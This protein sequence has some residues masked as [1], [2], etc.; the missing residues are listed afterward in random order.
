ME[1]QEG[2]FLEGD[3]DIPEHMKTATIG[4]EGV[5]P[6]EKRAEAKKTSSCNSCYLGDAFRCNSCPYLGEL[7]LPLPIPIPTRP[8]MT[9]QSSLSPSL[10]M[11]LVPRVNS[12]LLKGH[13]LILIGMPAFKPGEKVELSIMDDI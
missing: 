4:K 3:D 11:T 13:E 2:F 8:T 6:T 5:W 10:G 7:P 9:F 1:K 12:R